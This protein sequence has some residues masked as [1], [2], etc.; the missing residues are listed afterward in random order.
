MYDKLNKKNI[1]LIGGIIMNAWTFFFI[2]LGVSYLTAQFFRL[3][4]AI[5]KPSSHSGHHTVHN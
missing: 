3:I 4:D 5:E 1:C 2:L